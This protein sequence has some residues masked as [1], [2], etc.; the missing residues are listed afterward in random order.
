[1][2]SITEL[3]NQHEESAADQNRTPVSP[4]SPV[5]SEIQ[6]INEQIDNAYK[7][8]EIQAAIERLKCWVAANPQYREWTYPVFEQL[9]RREEGAKEAGLEAAKMGLSATEQEQRAR[10]SQ[11]RL[12]VHAEDM[13]QVFRSALSDARQ[14]LS[15]WQSVHPDDPIISLLNEHLDMEEEI[16]SQLHMR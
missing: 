8:T 9:Y 13:P 1:M 11:L 10:L 14:A 12:R 4:M 16:A 6:A 5:G 3:G 7:L 2:T 15:E